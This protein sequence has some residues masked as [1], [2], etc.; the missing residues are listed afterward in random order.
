MA[1]TRGSAHWASP[2]TSKSIFESKKN[3]S[4]LYPWKD[5]LLF[6]I[7]EPSE[8][9][10]SV[11]MY[12]DLRSEIERVSPKGTNIRSKSMNTVGGPSLLIMKMSI[13]VISKIRRSISNHS[14]LRRK[15]FL[16][17]RPSRRRWTIRL[18]TWISRSIER[19][20][21]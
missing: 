8:G 7:T 5:G 1:E 17:Q 4:N 3:I 15:L 2:I 16:R 20:I 21:S 9:N 13:T 10:A 18:G 14:N 11:L 19:G 12:Y 6:L